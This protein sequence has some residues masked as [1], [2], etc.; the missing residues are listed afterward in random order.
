MTSDGDARG[1]NSDQYPVPT[2]LA[3]PELDA[4]FDDQRPLFQSRTLL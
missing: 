1:W 2:C 3:A 4:P